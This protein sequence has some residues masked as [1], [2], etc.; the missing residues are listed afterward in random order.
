MKKHTVSFRTFLCL[1]LLFGLLRPIA[2]YVLE[3]PVWPDK[4]TAIM[5][6]DLGPT[7]VVLDD[8]LASWDASAADALGLWNA[9]MDAFQFNWS[10]ETG[11]SQKS[12]DGINS[13]FF[14]NSVFGDGF[15]E[16]VLAVTVTLFDFGQVEVTRESDVVV[17]QSYNFNSYRG[18]LKPGDLSSRVYDIHRVL[19]HE[20]GHVLGL[21]HPDDKGQNVT[22]I[23]NSVI[24]DLDTLAPD[25]IAGAESLYGLRITSPGELDILV[26][27]A[28]SFQV[29]SNANISYY[30]ATGLPS[31]LTINS[32][33]GLITGKVSLT[34]GYSAQVT[35][36]GKKNVTASLYVNITK[37]NGIGDI[38]QIWGLSVNRLITDSLRNRVYASLPL[39]ESVAIIDAAKLTLIKTIPV[40]S[41]PDGMAIS[42]DGN[43][44]FVAERGATKPEIGVI[45]L[46]ALVAEPSLPALF[47]TFD[48]A[49]GMDNRLFLTGWGYYK[50]KVVQLDSSTGEILALS[51]ENLLSGYLQMSPDRKTLYLGVTNSAPGALY[52][53][54][55]GSSAP[56][57][58]QETPFDR[59]SNG[60]GDLKLSHDGR[61]LCVPD[62]ATHRVLSIPADNLRGANGSYTLSHAGIATGAIAFSNDD[63]TLLVTNQ[64]F[65][66]QGVDIF[67]AKTRVYQR[68]I[69]TDYFVPLTMT[70]DS[71]GQYLFVGSNKQ[72][73]LRVY[74]LGSK[75]L[76]A[77]EPLPKSLLNVSTRM[78]TAPGQDTVIAGLI[79]SGNAPKNIL[80]RG[81]GPSLP[82]AGALED[83]ELDLYDRSGKLIANNHN[84]ANETKTPIL[85]TG[86]APQDS[87][88]S[89]LY[90]TLFPGSYT[91]QLSGA[92]GRDG[93]GLI[94]VYDLSPDGGSALANLST[95]GNVGT[96]DDV[97]IG[98]FIVSEGTPTKVLIRAIGPSL[99]KA[100]VTGALANPTLELH[101]ANGDLIYSND[102]WRSTQEA[103]IIAT[104][105]PPSDDRESAI[106]AT[107][108]P[109]AYTA[110][111]RGKDNTTGIA[112]VEIYNLD[113]TAPS[114]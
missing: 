90:V 110:I 84:W 24:G 40:H 96:G 5:Q 28:V 102:D 108:P 31:G 61:T 17:N 106:V 105:N 79:V 21:D 4:S 48:I 67:D 9:H 56:V 94:E 13:V 35:V 16:D 37:A 50:D 42:A 46:N 69:L 77:H 88:E 27:R 47:P 72:H 6:L 81:L 51:G 87:K 26:D 95:R 45:D 22:A 55:V 32:T 82:V 71:L 112:L 18:P 101:G 109:A 44:L 53:I 8:G 58:L 43:T 73:E 33:T 62:Q 25:D 100:G 93:V 59:I 7:N 63:Q 12:G 107:L 23:M 76:S 36:H 29:T 19:L 60:L 78:K 89:A 1:L 3:G 57:V 49:A 52:S 20:F 114:N 68:T 83:P 41:A 97:M 104:A 2:G 103:A 91:V 66:A 15:G 111:V 70:T 86:L 30:S 75:G 65:V 113:V 10:F 99:A 39:S 80:I 14:S 74:A 54:D 11:S 85:L 34:G 92:N 98:G 38:R 64:N